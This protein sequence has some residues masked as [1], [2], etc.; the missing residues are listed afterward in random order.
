MS[1]SNDSLEVNKMLVV[2]REMG[3]L[4]EAAAILLFMGVLDDAGQPLTT[5]TLDAHSEALIEIWGAKNPERSRCYLCNG[6][7]PADRL[8]PCYWQAVINTTNC[9]DIM[10]GYHA[11]SLYTMYLCQ[12]CRKPQKLYAKQIHQTLEKFN[13]PVYRLPEFCVTC[14]GKQQRR[15]ATPSTPIRTEIRGLTA[16]KEVVAASSEDTPQT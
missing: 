1:F 12:G 11:R 8:C 5:D 16:L 3:K 4:E 15:R 10:A 2:Y 14:A 9:R 7:Q 6:A 13:F